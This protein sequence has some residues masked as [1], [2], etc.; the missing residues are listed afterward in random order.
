MAF[1]E[2]P[3]NEKSIRLFEIRV[4]R[5]GKGEIARRVRLSARLKDETIAS[6]LLEEEAKIKQDIDSGAILS[7]KEKAAKEAEEAARLAEERAKLRTFRDYANDVYMARKDA[8]LTENGKS[9]YRLLLD[10]HIFPAFGSLHITDISAEMIEAALLDLQKDGYSQ[11][12]ITKY[13][14]VMNGVLKL[15][16]RQKVIPFNPVQNVEKP[17]VGKEERAEI[18]NKEKALTQEQ[19]DTLL[20]YMDRTVTL[21]TTGITKHAESLLWRAFVVL[22]LDS[23]ARRGELCGLRWRDINLEDGEITIRNNLQYSPTKGVYEAAPKNGKFRTIDIGPDTIALLKQLKAEQSKQCISRYVFSQYA[24]KS[25]E[26][27]NPQSP[28]RYLARIGKRIGLDDLHPHT[29][30]HTG[31][32][33]AILNGADVE[34]VSERAGHSDSAITMRFY[35]HSNKAAMR[36]VGEIARGIWTKKEA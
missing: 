26:P 4:R 32:S 28:T 15:A 3:T 30:R 13:L 1:R 35:S 16:A 6:R 19:V 23:W 29:L 5:Y 25:P 7:R 11:A 33:L 12:T 36:K 17:E 14:N 20:A 31:I 2:I 8:K 18:E 24:D 21:K 34:S 27:I 9:N 10:K 22:A